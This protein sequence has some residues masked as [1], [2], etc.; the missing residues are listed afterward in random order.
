MTSDRGDV[1][2]DMAAY[3]PGWINH[4]AEERR[5]IRDA[6]EDIIPIAF[7]IALP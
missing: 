4:I 7:H 1:V 5:A 6:V 2:I 3:D